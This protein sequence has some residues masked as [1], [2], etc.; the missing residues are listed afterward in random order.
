MIK[1]FF[2]FL[3]DVEK[4]PEVEFMLDVAHDHHYPLWDDHVMDHDDY[5]E[6]LVTMNDNGTANLDVQE[7][8]EHE[9]PP[10]AI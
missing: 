3:Q 4:I 1:S 8:T 5:L 7:M 6:K 9:E 10:S 2:K